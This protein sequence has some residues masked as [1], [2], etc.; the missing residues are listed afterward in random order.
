MKKLYIILVALALAV[1]TIMPMAIPVAAD[2]PEVVGYVT[3][4][5]QG[6][7]GVQPEMSF[8]GTVKL[9]SDG[10]VVGNWHWHF[11]KSYP[12]DDPTDYLA[13][14]EW[15]CDEF[16]GLVFPSPNTAVFWGEFT[17]VNNSQ[18]YQGYSFTMMFQITDN[19]EPG[20]GQDTWW[21]PGL[22]YPYAVEHGN[23]QVYYAGIP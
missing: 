15:K 1:A 5:D 21:I 6:G 10:T 20:V 12:N 19:G 3:G 9:L 4:S 13:N 8:G 11:F 16:E 23:F 17:C 14:T 18:K 22:P 2:S 7:Y